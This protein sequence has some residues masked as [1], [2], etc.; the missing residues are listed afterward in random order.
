[1]E[2]EALTPLQDPDQRLIVY[3]AADDASQLALDEIAH[4]AAARKPASRR[5][6]VN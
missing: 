4:R 5:C 1:M 2:Y 3:P 6:E